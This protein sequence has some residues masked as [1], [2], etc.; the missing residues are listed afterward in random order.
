MLV[1]EVRVNIEAMTLTLLLPVILSLIILAE[2]SQM[3]EERNL[4]IHT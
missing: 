2:D 3:D 4:Q 1:D